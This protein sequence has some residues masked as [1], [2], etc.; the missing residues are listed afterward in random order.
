LLKFDAAIRLAGEE[1][2]SALAK[3]RWRTIDRANRILDA[4]E[5]FLKNIK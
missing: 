1:S 3:D 5:N 4:P 2:W